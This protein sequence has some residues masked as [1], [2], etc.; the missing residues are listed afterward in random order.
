MNCPCQS[1]QS[2]ETCCQ[3]FLTGSALPETAEKLMRSRYT[4][5]TQADVAYLKK[6]LAP[7]SRHDFDEAATRKWAETAKWKGLQILATVK[8]TAQDKKG[9]VEFI[10]TYEADGEGLDHH[11]V[12]E[13]RKAENGQWLFVE[14]DGHTH[15][16]GEG[17]HHHHEKPQTV[18]REAPK[19]GRNDPCTCG[20]G[21]KYKKCCGTDAA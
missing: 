5:F 16:E 4:A 14:G 15:A 7:E 17:H 21:K 13:F 3:P 12:S 1:Q 19:I 20:S 11:E 9:T 10:A 8:G 18:Q 6:T 2:F